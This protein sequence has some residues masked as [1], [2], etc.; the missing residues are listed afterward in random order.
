MSVAQVQELVA[1]RVEKNMVSRFD[2]LSS[3]LNDLHE[4]QV[5]TQSQ[6][7]DLHKFQVQTQSQLHEFQG[8]L[9]EF[10]GHL[11]ELTTQIAQKKARR[12]I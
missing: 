4:F 7:H 12:H 2:I 1:L 5:Q 10:Q 9:D 3:Q 8:H 6:L 11:D